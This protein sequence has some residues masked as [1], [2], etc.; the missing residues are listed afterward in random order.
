MK[1]TICSTVVDE[2]GTVIQDYRQT[3][4]HNPKQKVS[5]VRETSQEIYSFDMDNGNLQNWLC[6]CDEPE[7]DQADKN[8]A[9]GITKLPHHFC[10][11]CEGII[12]ILES[13]RDEEY[14]RDMVSTA[15]Y[16]ALVDLEATIVNLR[17][18]KQQILSNAT[19]EALA[20]SEIQMDTLTNVI[21]M[22]AEVRVNLEEGHIVHPLNSLD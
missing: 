17:T 5:M 13:P 3:V 22:V 14:V 9:D 8:R 10:E 16:Q 2:F 15:C 21:A 18:S 4:E 11:I 19:N 6:L 7:F 1:E 20:A 12:L